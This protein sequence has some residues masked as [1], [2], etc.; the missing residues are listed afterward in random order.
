MHEIWWTFS[1]LDENEYQYFKSREYMS[2]V[3]IFKSHNAV[4][5]KI[6]HLGTLYY[7][8]VAFYTAGICLLKANKRNTRTRSEICS[9]LTIKIGNEQAN[10][11]WA[12]EPI[13]NF[14][15]AKMSDFQKQS[16]RAV[17]QRRISEA[18]IFS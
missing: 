15:F 1:F 11:G 9:K 5:I 12:A 7:W 14:V 17:Y 8:I 4:W 10:A 18:Y 2:L 3:L 6:F 16:P 13:Q